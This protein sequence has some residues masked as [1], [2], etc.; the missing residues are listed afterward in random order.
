[1]GIIIKQSIKNTI[2]SYLGIA[3]GFVSIILLFP[4]ILTSD[5]YGL[6]RLLISIAMISAQFCQLGMKN[7]NIRYFP[8][9]NQQ[10]ESKHGLL[11]LTIVVPLI[12][13]L[14]FA[15]FFLL[16]ESEIVYY[17][18]DD[19]TLFQE[20]Y[21]YLLPLVLFVLFYEVLNSY[22]RALQDSVTGPFLNE[23]ML[24][25]ITIILLVIY[26]FD[27]ISFPQ[28]MLLFVVN[29]GLQ[30]AYL[31]FTLYQRGELSFTV[32]FRKGNRRFAKLIGT[33]GL[34]SLLGGL[35]TIIVNNIDILMVSSMTDFT[36]TAVY[37]I[38][39]SV[40]SVIAVPQRS[41][42][43]I[44]DPVLANFMKNKKY[45]EVA[46]LYRRTSLNQIIA[47]SLIFI[48][49]W[50]NIHNLMDLLPPAYQGAE[51]VIIVIGFAKL[52]DMSTGINGGIIVNSKH[53][54]FHLYINVFLIFLAILTNYLLIPIYGMLGAAIATAISILIYN[55]VK[56]I[57]VWITFSMQPFR[58][59]AL[60]ILLLAATCLGTSFFIPYLY[61]F[62]V[63]VII[64][65][66]VIA[67]IF[68][69]TILLFNL[70][71]DV[72]NLIQESINRL[73]LFLKS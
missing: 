59:N 37:F 36:N 25:L 9:F 61:N 12:G 1:M 33:Y 51:W 48:G 5:Q 16:F 20:Y 63:D 54:R 49:I 71:D 53:Y 23:V 13:F 60:T 35:S 46:S 3:L 21:L 4:Y 26:H 67:S 18:Q 40:G 66:L 2:I 73:Q 15:A 17:F 22:F 45:D 39:F 30:S 43:K 62:F 29:Y 19:S 34:Y 8:Y 70:S 41:I 42:L 38:A 50:A 65:S 24:R 56:F 55:I 7:I 6:T 52:F 68:I 32:P 44:A 28:F 27:L 69:G 31:L 57:F 10:R 47:G 11:F 58:W 72:K 14:I 64:R